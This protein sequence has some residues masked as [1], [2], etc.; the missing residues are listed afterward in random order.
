[1]TQPDTV[2]APEFVTQAVA[3]DAQAF[4]E[5]FTKHQ[6]L[7]FRFIWRKCGN[8]TVAEDLAAEVWVRALRRID[9]FEWNGTDIA[10]WLLAISR[11]IVADYFRSGRYRK[12][13]TV[14]VFSDGAEAA[15][16]EFEARPDEIVVDHIMNSGVLVLLTELKPEHRE[17]LTLRFLDGFSLAETALKLGTD[18]SAVKAR[19][20]RATRS[21]ARL[22]RTEQEKR[23]RPR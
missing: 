4:A 14:G 19:Q 18:E 9:T 6:G 11:N 10:A 1:M 16:N 15:S 20:Y 12:E 17:V 23:Q 5:I 13:V 3:G 21:L 22:W 8:H 2:E 7:V